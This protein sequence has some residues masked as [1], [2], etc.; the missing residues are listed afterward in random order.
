[1][2]LWLAALTIWAAGT[3][4]WDFRHRRIPNA[5]VL[6]GAG[7]VALRWL[8]FADPALGALLAQGCVGLL[9]LWI[10]WRWRLM[11]GGDVKLG[12]VLAALNLQD[13]GWALALALG[14]AALLGGWRSRRLHLLPNALPDGPRGGIPFGPLLLPP[15]VGLSWWRE[16]AG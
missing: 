9:A 2:I 11:G 7:L 6:A 14:A 16:L 13:F 3:A 12:I 10:P 15:F 5:A 8:I 4:L 1:M